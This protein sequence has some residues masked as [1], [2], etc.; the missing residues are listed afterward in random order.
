MQAGT[1]EMLNGDAEL[2]ISGR[3]ILKLSD[4]KSQSNEPYGWGGEYN[5]RPVRSM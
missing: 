4:K 2:M 3:P 5:K 1:A